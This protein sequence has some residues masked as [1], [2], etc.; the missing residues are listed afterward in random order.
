MSAIVDSIKFNEN[1]LDKVSYDDVRKY[2]IEKHNEAH[3]I[4]KEVAK[5]LKKNLSIFENKRGMWSFRGHA[6]DTHK[7]CIGESNPF[8]CVIRRHNTAKLLNSTGEFQSVEV[9]EYWTDGGIFFREYNGK[10]C[11]VNTMTKPQPYGYADNPPK[12]NISTDNEDFN[13]FPRYFSNNHYADWFWEDLGQDALVNVIN[14]F[15]ATEMKQKVDEDLAHAHR[16]VDALMKSL[17]D[18]NKS[19]YDRIT[20]SILVRDGVNTS[21]TTKYVIEVTKIDD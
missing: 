10:I 20:K 6:G 1:V 18:I 17:Q 12:W 19:V 14:E 11:Y 3:A 9:M 7:R 15:N 8:N 13:M 5:F 21:K 2:I 4:L 16:V